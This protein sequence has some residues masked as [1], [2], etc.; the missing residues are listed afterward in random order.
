MTALFEGQTL[1]DRFALHRRLGR[2]SIG[3]TWLAREL[4]RDTWAA[5]KIL[6]PEIA[7]SPEAAHWLNTEFPRLR[8]LDHPR[9][10]SVSERIDLDGH[11]AFS[12]DY[13]SGG[14]SDRLRGQSTRAIVS[15]LGPLLEALARVHDHGLVHGGVRAS[16]ILWDARNGPALSDL[17]FAGLVH[18]C[19]SSRQRTLRRRVPEETRSGWS[20]QLLSGETPVPADD[21]FALGAL[22]YEW[23]RGQRPFRAGPSREDAPRLLAPI[24]SPSAEP[25][26]VAQSLEPLITR[27]LA[28]H[29]GDRP[30]IA[31]VATELQTIAGAGRHDAPDDLW[32]GEADW[33]GDDPILIRSGIPDAPPLDAMHRDPSRERASLLRGGTGVALG[34]LL[35]AAFGVFFVLPRSVENR[36]VARV[37]EVRAPAPRDEV[38]GSRIGTKIGTRTGTGPEVG[39]ERP[40]ME[41]DPADRIR[42]AELRIAAEEA[43]GRVLEQQEALEARAVGTWAADDYAAAQRSARVGE[44]HLN[45]RDYDRAAA[46]LKRAVVRFESIETRASALLQESTRAGDI[47]LSAGNAGEATTRFS[48]A[49]QLDPGSEVARR[50]IDRAERIAEVFRWIREGAQHEA[51]DALEAAV[52]AYARAAELDPDLERAR[53]ALARVGDQVVAQR[54][55]DAMSRGMSSLGRRDFE[56]AI[57]AFGDA[58]AIR[59]DEAETSAALAQARQGWTLA[60]LTRLRE[61]AAHYEGNERWSEAVEQHDAA[62]AMDP[63]LALAQEGK[64][65]ASRRAAISAE[66]ENY[67]ADPDRLSSPRVFTRAKETLAAVAAFENPG[68]RLREQMASVSRLVELA[69]TPIPVELVSNLDTRIVLHRVGRLG[70]FDRREIDLRPGTYTIVGM[71]N[72]YRDVRKNFTVRPGESPTPVVIRCE[73][74][75]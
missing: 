55:A 19:W 51:D 10:I 63:T 1:S 74:E 20:P 61:R 11:C 66:L 3:E 75:I 69:R 32:A 54:Y 45:T 71:R 46:E 33:H 25:D 35:C 47:A 52:R 67:R 73:E 58:Q 64:A 16:N 42:L 65:R 17:G 30:D 7:T 22:L 39:W 29:R 9:V 8:S 14:N 56:T 28:E 62:L 18:R 48:L 44:A 23:I 72:G 37:T 27:M 26:D 6:D 31:A 41:S 38:S 68:P 12:M 34:L 43:L 70:S 59:P 5:L 60:R 49:L 57:R 36:T 21:V 53:S 13:C 4:A 50:G 24:R 40:G 2:G 15:S